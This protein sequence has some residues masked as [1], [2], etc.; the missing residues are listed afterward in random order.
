M[1]RR[2]NSPAPLTLSR[3]LLRANVVCA[4]LAV[5]LVGGTLMI[6]GT[7]Q[8]RAL[9]EHNLQL[10]AR[11]MAYTIEA[12]VVF[13]DH[14]AAQDSLARMATANSVEAVSAFDSHGQRLAAWTRV[15]VD[16]EDPVRRVI[17]RWLLKEPVTE[18][19][20]SEG[21]VVGEVRVQGSPDGLLGF[22]EAGF[23]W[24]FACMILSMLGT[25][26]LS[27]RIFKTIT[28]PL[29]ELARV[30]HQVRT[31]RSFG[32]RVPPARIAD[33]NDLATDFNSLLD[34]L[35]KWEAG[36]QRENQTL[37]HQANHDSLTGLPNRLSFEASLD[38]ALTRADGDR[39]RFALLFL[40]CD[41]FKDINDTLGHA[42]GDHVLATVARRIRE[43][44][45]VG[46]IVARIGGDEFAA[47][48]APLRDLGDAARIAHNV[49]VAMREPIVL[50]DGTQVASSVS[51]G[52]AVY[53][54]DAASATSLIRVADAAM[55]ESKARQRGLSAFDQSG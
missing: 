35:E 33:L 11:S 41:R 32:Q 47:L 13:N 22:F 36:M 53:P 45:R 5:S 26:Y 54:D 17:R 8:L 28:A 37:A 1:T 6:V 9:A 15:G 51:I 20:S 18:P 21:A 25:L 24:I 38:Q 3:A 50:D 52:V 30:T 7:L 43:Q 44:L 19:V 29:V 31:A 34:E 12:A 27:R 14:A 39:L 16:K 23:L 55:Y 49:A 10:V 2:D 40:D 46:D 4:L 42:A 48:L